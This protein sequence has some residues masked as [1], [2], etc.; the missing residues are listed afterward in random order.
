MAQMLDM[1][2]N[3]YLTNNNGGKC[4]T[5]LFK[6]SQLETIIISL[7]YLLNEMNLLKYV[8]IVMIFSKPFSFL[9]LKIY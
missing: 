7:K 3:H 6:F 1:K 8:V 4:I 9:Y 2:I 5:A